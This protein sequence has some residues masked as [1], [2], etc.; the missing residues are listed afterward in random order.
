M[1]K[2]LCIALG[3]AAWALPA[4]AQ[5]HV[6]ETAKGTAAVHNVLVNT[7]A[8]QLDVSTRTLTT[9]DG[10]FKRFALEIWNDDATNTAWCGFNGSVSATAGAANYGRRISPRT[11]W[12]LAVDQTI[13]VWCVS[14][15][16]A[17][18]RL[19]LTQLY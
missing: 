16:A 7:T 15:V 10:V 8:V 5:Q 13:R 3:L 18:A 14:D 12:T 19:V 1:L 11:S 9:L 2:T 6:Y 17:G 4:Q